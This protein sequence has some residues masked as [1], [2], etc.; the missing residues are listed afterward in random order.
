MRD[1]L[2]QALEALIASCDPKHDPKQVAD[3]IDALIKEL[4]KPDA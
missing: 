2:K 1:L 3:A 4:E